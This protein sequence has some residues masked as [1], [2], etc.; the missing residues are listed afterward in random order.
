MKRSPIRKVSKKKQAKAEAEGKPIFST[1]ERCKPRA[2]VGK[3]REKRRKSDSSKKAPT[4]KTVDTLWSLVIRER[5]NHECQL[6]GCGSMQCA[7]LMDAH[8]VFGRGFAVRWDLRG[9]LCLCKAHHN[10]FVHS[11][12]RQAAAQKEIE[13]LYD[14]AE[15]AELLALHYTTRKNTAALRRNTYAFLTAELARLKARAA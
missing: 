12:N 7:S 1:F 14:P 11:A 8:H 2:N 9:G 6:W 4:T 13:A 3:K 5:A 15:Y 10:Y